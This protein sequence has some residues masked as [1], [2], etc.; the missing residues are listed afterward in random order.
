MQNPTGSSVP[1]TNNE[2]YKKQVKEVAPIILEAKD[3]FRN[4]LM[5]FSFL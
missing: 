2:L 3:Q 4:T 1:Y 5:T